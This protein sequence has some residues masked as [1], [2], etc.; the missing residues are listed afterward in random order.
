M[1]ASRLSRVISGKLEKPIRVVM[2]APEGLG[3]TTFASRAP[4]PVFIASEDGTSHLDVQ[5]L[6]DVDTWRGVLEALSELESGAH[7]YQTVV[8]DT[9]DWLE[10]MIWAHIC[11]SEGKKSIEDFGYG[12]GYTAALAEWRRLCHA[13]DRLRAAR[14]MNAIILAHSHVKTF[15]NPAGEDFDRYELKVHAKAAGVLKEWCDAVLFAEYETLVR[16]KDGKRKGVSNGARIVHTERTA[17]WDAKNR[18]DLPA[19]L[20]LDWDA[21]AAAIVVGQPASPAE[22]EAKID[23]LLTNVKPEIS[24]RVKA[25]VKKANGNAAELARIANYLAAQKGT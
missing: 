3:K 24:E 13:L 5:R 17:A 21:F 23:A 25:A 20:P 1:K 15:K 2:Y 22:F 16:E 10:P 6:P 9:A 19:I 18:F 8:L 4:A 7:D 12:K 11:E 14:K